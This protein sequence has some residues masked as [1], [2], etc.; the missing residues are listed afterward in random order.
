MRHL[1][2]WVICV[3]ILHPVNG[4]TLTSALA[5]DQLPAFKMQHFPASFHPV[6][7]KSD[8]LITG[9][10]ANFYSNIFYL[11]NTNLFELRSKVDMLR[12]MQADEAAGSK[13]DA[14]GLDFH[15]GR[16]RYQ[17]AGQATLFGPAFWY[18]INSEWSVGIYSRLSVL[19]SA[20]NIPDEINYPSYD[21]KRT[22]QPFNIRSFSGNAM[23]MGSIGAH[24]SRNISFSDWDV[25]VGMN[26]QWNF[27][28]DMLGVRM[29]QDIDAWTKLENNSVR[30]SNASI[31]WHYTY[32][33]E[34]LSKYKL[35]VNG[36]GASLDFGIAIRPKKSSLKWEAMLA[37]NQLGFIE[38]YKSTE[39]HDI[40]FDRAIELN[41]ADFSSF[42]DLRS[43]S[44]KLEEQA[45][46]REAGMSTVNKVLVPTKGSLSG[47]F[48]IHMDPNLQI[49]SLISFPF[50]LADPRLIVGVQYNFRYWKVFPY[51][52]LT[53]WQTYS[54][55]LSIRAGYFTLGSNNVSA[56]FNSDRLDHADLHLL[57]SYNWN[58]KSLK[59]KRNRGTD[60]CYSF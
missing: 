51:A 12:T 20:G 41:S 34:T 25:N 16:S 55:G 32:T 19:G 30:I 26:V 53:N 46:G 27:G 56:F 44:A 52:T 4:Q 18:K 48:L 3:W 5:D 14:I 47:S 43:Y 1:A 31:H 28:L 54:P 45:L 23:S 57:F 29:N 36:Q 24:A 8:I 21:S 39:S 10:S 2:L 11:K 42:N 15:T 37:L 59:K 50:S 17:A 38:Y 40:A 60:K 58:D 13:M 6:W 35:K 9:G 7:M 49:Q 22:N 33:N